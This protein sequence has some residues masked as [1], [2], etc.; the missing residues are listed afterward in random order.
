MSDIRRWLQDLGLDQ[1]AVAFESNDIDMALLLQVD[2][3]ALKDI[4]VASAGH[5][6][7]LR[8]AIQRLAQAPTTIEPGATH[9]PDTAIEP[10]SAERRQ[11]TVMFCDL[12]GR[13]NCRASSTPKHCAS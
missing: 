7:R 8:A 9:E 1:Y 5:R 12:V 10:T 13:R 4:G 6:L 3:Q 2:D 11:L